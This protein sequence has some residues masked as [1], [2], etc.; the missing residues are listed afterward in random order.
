MVFAGEWKRGIV[1]TK[2]ATRAEKLNEKSHDWQA[3]RAKNS[4]QSKEIAFL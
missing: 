2:G 1:K 3:V 4:N